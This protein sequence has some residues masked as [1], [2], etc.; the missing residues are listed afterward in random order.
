MRTSVPRFVALG[1]HVMTVFSPAASSP[2]ALQLC[3][4]RSFGWTAAARPVVDAVPMRHR[5]RAEIKGMANDRL[6]VVRHQ[7][8]LDQRALRQGAAGFS[9]GCATSRSNPREYSAAPRLSRAHDLR[10]NFQKAAH[11]RVMVNLTMNFTKLTIN[12]V[13]YRGRSA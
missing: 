3:E 2:E 4:S 10:I 12:I 9:G 11:S 8:L 1:V 6:K 7:P 13:E 5:S